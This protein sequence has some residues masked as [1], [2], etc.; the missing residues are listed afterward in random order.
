[1]EGYEFRS[2]GT[3]TVNGLP[4]SDGARRAAER[5]GLSLEGHFSS[6][7]TPSAIEW[8]DLLLPMAPKHLQRI[9]SEGGGEKSVLLGAFAKGMEGETE[10]YGVPDPFGG[11]D[12]TYEA[13]F[14]TLDAMVSAALDRLSKEDRK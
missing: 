13:T 8:A 11:N 7:L 1:M 10:E 9:S 4:A 3:S 6:V 5:H 14:L 2:A 12:E